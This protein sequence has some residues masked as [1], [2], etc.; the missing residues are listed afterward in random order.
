MVG[1]SNPLWCT[2]KMKMLISMYLK[3]YRTLNISILL[4]FDFQKVRYNI[5]S[6]K[7]NKIIYKMLWLTWII[8][9]IEGT[10]QLKKI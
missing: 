7:L 3:I 2:K 4:L 10:Q 8:K 5:D 6:M 1:G 9:E